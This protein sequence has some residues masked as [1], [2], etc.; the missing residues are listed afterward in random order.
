MLYPTD[1]LLC[2]LRH[3]PPDEIAIC[4]ACRSE[5][6]TDLMPSCLRCCATIGPHLNP[7][8]DCVSCR[9][10]SFQFESALRLGPYGGKLRDLILRIKDIRGESLAESIGRL[11]AERDHQRLISFQPDA[12]VPVPVHWMRRIERGYN[13]SDALAEAIAERLGRR[14]GRGWLR[15]VKATPKQITQSAAA[16]RENVKG[17]F[18]VVRGAPVRTMRILLVDDVMTT[19]AT[20]NEAARALRQAGAAQVGVAVL[21]RR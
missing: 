19:G 3:E 13:Q 17:A 20:A 11:W 10:E 12:V 21:A 16:R 14:S 2:A 1:C 9:G 5:L 4:P 15:R 6:L 7:E 18:R 8:T